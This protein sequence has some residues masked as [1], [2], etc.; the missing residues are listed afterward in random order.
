MCQLLTGKT[1]KVTAAQ[2][3]GF[4]VK[5]SSVFEILQYCTENCYKKVQEEIYTVLYS[6]GIYTGTISAH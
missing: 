5:M 6:T 4:T 3:R 1:R 2:L